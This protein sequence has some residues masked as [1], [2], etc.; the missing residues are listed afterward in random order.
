MDDILKSGYDETPLGC[1][2]IDWFVNEVKKNKM[3]FYLKNTKKD[4]AMTEDDEEGLENF[5]IRR[6]CGKGINSDKIRD[7]CHLTGRYRGPAHDTC[8]MNVTQKRSSF[9]PLVFHNL[10]NF[11]CHLFFQGL[12]DIKN[13]NV[14]FKILP[15]T[16]E[17][18]TTV[19]YGCIRFIDSYRF[20]S[21]SLDKLVKTLVDISHKTMK[22]LKK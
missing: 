2:N 3:A 16:D 12:V 10:S 6:F 5:D 22:K 4:I 9:I 14:I 21:S 7:H 15:K 11:D 18:Y 13:D 1:A 8:N 19:T 20:S 17:E